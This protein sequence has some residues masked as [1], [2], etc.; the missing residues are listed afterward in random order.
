VEQVQWLDF[1]GGPGITAWIDNVRIVDGDQTTDSGSGLPSPFQSNA[2]SAALDNTQFDFSTGTPGFFAQ[3]NIFNVGGDSVQSS[4][5]S[6]NQ[7][8]EMTVEVNGPVN[9][10]FDWKVSSEAG[11]DFLRVTVYDNNFEPTTITKLITGEQDWATTQLSIPPGIYFLVWDYSK[12]SS[13]SSGADAGWVDRVIIGGVSDEVSENDKSKV[14][15]LA[16]IIN[17]ILN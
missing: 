11:K 9:V 10:S 8:T 6:N 3:S 7:K 2:L 14:K 13:V 12:N 15:A 16:P 1:S 5:I 17:L 4:N